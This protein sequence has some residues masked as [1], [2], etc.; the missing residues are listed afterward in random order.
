MVLYQALWSFDDDDKDD[1][2]GG[3]G[4]GWKEPSVLT[5]IIMEAL[6]GGWG[7]LR[8]ER[9]RVWSSSIVGRQ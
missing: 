7:L 1:D 6:T 2:D 9:E 3:G 5:T 8:G 4:R